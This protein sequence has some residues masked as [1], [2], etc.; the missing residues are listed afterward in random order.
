VNDFAEYMEVIVE[1]TWEDF[2]R[3]GNSVRH[4]YLACVAILHAV[5]RAAYPGDP[6]ALAEQ[7]RKESQEFML[8]EEVAQHFKHGQRRW[9]KRAKAANPDAL[10]ITHP[11]GLEGGLKSLQLHSL[12]FLARDAVKFLRTKLTP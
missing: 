10:L 4:A 5:D 11:L 8:V 12:H 9:V 7:W 2:R 3:N 1:P 6:I